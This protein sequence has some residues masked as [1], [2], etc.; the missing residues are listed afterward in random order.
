MF[1]EIEAN[2]SE[3]TFQPHQS[4]TTRFS[5]KPFAHIGTPLTPW[6]AHMT[7]PAPASTIAALNAGR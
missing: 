6:Y 4:L 2:L 5:M 1:A 3:F 7:E